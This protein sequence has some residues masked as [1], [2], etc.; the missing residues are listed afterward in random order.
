MIS[1]LNKGHTFHACINKERHY[2]S[3]FMRMFTD[4]SVDR[5]RT[6]TLRHTHMH[7]RNIGWTYLVWKGHRKHVV[8]HT[9]SEPHGSI[10]E[11]QMELRIYRE[12]SASSCLW[13]QGL[14]VHLGLGEP[15]MTSCEWDEGNSVGQGIGGFINAS[16]N[17]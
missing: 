9:G 14:P 17:Q 11:S 6:H 7:T 5:T 1:S 13:K 4:E 8:G 2:L 12:S 10:T 16:M 3:W 15:K